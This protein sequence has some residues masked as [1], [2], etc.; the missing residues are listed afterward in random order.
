MANFEELDG[1]IWKDNGLH[2]RQLLQLDLIESPPYLSKFESN[3]V[4]V[5][6]TSYI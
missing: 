1:A 3:S 6:R 2:N 5:G 4:I